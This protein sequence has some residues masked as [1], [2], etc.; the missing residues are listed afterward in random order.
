MNYIGIIVA[1]DEEL[2]AVLHFSEDISRKEKKN[3]EFIECKIKGRN[4]V[5]IKSGVGKVNAARATQILIYEYQLIYIV[6]VGVAGA[7]ND[8]LQIGDVVISEKIIQHDFDITAFGHSKGYVPQ[9]GNN[10]SAD[11][12]LLLEFKK[13]IDNS[14]DKMFNIKFG[15][16]ASGDIFCTKLEMKNKIF[17]KFDADV[18]DMECAAIAQVCFLE[19]MP[20]I[21]IRSVSDI[22]NEKNVTTYNENLKLAAKRCSIVLKDFLV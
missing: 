11:E 13:D 5:I 20:F 2:E 10:I 12:K 16:V 18:V 9:V 22:P 1:M 8:N 21:A 7:V 17:Q 15:V 6:N 19:K 14:L 3:I 4:C